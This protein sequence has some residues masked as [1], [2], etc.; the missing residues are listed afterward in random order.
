MSANPS[1]TGGGVI[2]RRW[3][4]KVSARRSILF[5]TALSFTVGGVLSQPAQLDQRWTVAEDGQVI[6]ISNVMPNSTA[7]VKSLGD[8]AEYV[9]GCKLPG[10][11]EAWRRHRPEVERAFR[12]AI[13]LEKLPE[14]TSLNVRTTAT[15]DFGHYLVENVI[16]E[17]RPGFPVTA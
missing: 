16:F 3:D 17:S 11:E 13:G 12:K 6:D 1:A 14:R 9:L 15:H 5:V 7:L 4:S 10:D 8:A 2:A